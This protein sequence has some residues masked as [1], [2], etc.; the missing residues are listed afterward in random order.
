MKKSKFLQSLA[1][2][3]LGLAT[4]M[5]ALAELRQNSA[6]DY[7][8][9][10]A[11]DYE[12]FRQM[13]ATGNPYANAVLTADIT[14]KDVI[15]KGDV[16]FHYRGTFDGQ[17][18]TITMDN[19]AND[20]E[21]HPWGLFQ[22]TEP[23]CV[24]KNLKVSGTV[25]NQYE[26]L[27]SIVGEAR[28]TRVENCISDATLTAN[29]YAG[30]LIGA[31][32]GVNFV[33]N[34]AFIGSINVSEAYGIIGY[35]QNNVEI[36]SCYVD[37]TF[38]NPTGSNQFM[39]KTDAGQIFL[40]N[41]Y[42]KRNN[43]AAGQETGVT[44]VSSSDDMSN[45]K[46]CLDLNIKGRNGVVWY[47]HGDHPYPFKGTNGQFVTWNS[48]YDQPII[49]QTKCPVN[50]HIYTGNHE[51]CGIC[52]A[53]DP[54]R[55]IDPL[56]SAGEDHMYANDEI[57][58]GLIRYKL[59]SDGTA[60]VKGT[61]KNVQ[62]TEL[63]T[64][65]H[66]PEVIR[67]QNADY[68]VTNIGDGAFGGSKIEYCYIPKTIKDI[69]NNA[70]NKSSELTYVHFADG[71][72]NVGLW[73]GHDVE[74]NKE[75]FYNSPIEKV[76]IGRNL[77]WIA[78]VNN[79]AAFED[80]TTLTNVFFGPLVTRV[81]N[82]RYGDDPRAGYNYELFLNC[83]NIRNI[84]F[85]G[86]DQSLSTPDIEGYIA[87]GLKYATSIYVNRNITSGESD[88]TH[89]DTHSYTSYWKNGIFKS[90]ENVTFG[91]YVKYVGT[92]LLGGGESSYN[93]TLKNVDFTYATRL[94]RIY[95][96]AFKECPDATFVG[97]AGQYPLKKI[98]EEAFYNCDK[99]E[100]INFGTQLE[101]I[102]ESAFDDCAVLNFI[103]IP[104]TVTTIDVDA[105]DDCPKLQGVSFES[106]ATPLDYSQLD[107]RFDGDTKIISTLYLGRDISNT[108]TDCSIL[109]DDSP[110][111]ASDGSLAN[112]TIGPEVTYLSQGLFYGLKAIS[113]ITFEYAEQKLKFNG[114]PSFVFDIGE[115]SLLTDYNPVS[116]LLIDR[117]LVNAE[118]KL[119][120]G[121]EWGKARELVRD[122]TFGEHIYTIYE[123]QFEG[124]EGLQTLLVSSAIGQIQAKAFK[125]AD[126]LT[127][128][129]FAG[130][131]HIFEEAFANCTGLKT[132]IVGDDA[133]SIEEGAFYN[134][135]KIEEIII[136]S[137]GSAVESSATAFSSTTYT[138]AKLRSTYDTSVE[139][140]V[141]EHAPWKLFEN[142]P[143]KQ[144]NDYVANASD[145]SGVYEHA[146]IPRDVNEGQLD[147]LYIPF[148]WD[149]YF[150]GSD[151]EVY[152]LE[153]DEDDRYEETFEDININKGI[154]AY[155]AVLKQVDILA[156]RT[157][158]AGIY[159][160]KTKYSASGVH[161]TR[162]LFFDN[163]VMVTNA[164]HDI[165]T[166]DSNAGSKFVVGGNERDIEPDE[167][168]P[169]Y[170]FEDGVIKMV[171]ET[172]SFHT[173]DV[174]LSG[175]SYTDLQVYNVK[176]G[177]GYTYTSKM[178]LS[179]HALLEG[180]AT[181]YN[182][183]YNVLAP[184]WCTVYV[185]TGEENGTV[186]M[187]EI[188]D[189][190][191]TARQ[192]VV[193]KTE[194]EAALGAN[195]LMTYVTNGSSATDLYA[196]NLL[197][198]VSEDTPVA[199]VS[200]ADGYVYVLSC[201]SQNKNTG[202]Y[203]FSNG[204]TLGAGKAY[205][206]PSD[207]SNAGAKACLF[208][209]DDDSN[210]IGHAVI[211]GNNGVAYDLM[212]KRIDADQIDAKG[213]YIIDNKKVIK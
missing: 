61:H 55:K 205:L 202:F 25:T 146:F 135:P 179:F 127:T 65:V 140:I 89:K 155:N 116:S 175:S 191:I 143:F 52:G 152:V 107:G 195:D 95:D 19:V 49:G 12:E 199:D 18:H 10:S 162:N 210:G 113:S 149:S 130:S 120:K 181:F 128:V 125:G 213:I 169:N 88:I 5:P 59:N 184:E 54:D 147:L 97:L 29:S 193:I 206:K 123:S 109:G 194:N 150:F 126:A 144:N 192:A 70:F 171:N 96:K 79:D 58:V 115:A 15:G 182:E 185:V 47:Q 41:Y 1:I 180:Y 39:K 66:I 84:Y 119:I 26:A 27:G 154:G 118:G 187:A 188:E 139:T 132:I 78:D 159:A 186:Q 11:T 73:L 172:Q 42:H 36:K 164:K 24:I 99:L 44:M 204:K 68:T 20:T 48:T 82:Y 53:L 45:G 200:G 207:F 51:I 129:T 166:S 137:D 34:C 8:I 121:S 161:A 101:S 134:C 142:R 94:E 75:L 178:A 209:F 183:E 38:S 76:Y 124:F 138:N 197:H 189:R 23:G 22:Y 9:A 72:S 102:G 174:V 93:H 117:Y 156:V 63:A 160:V 50:G 35:V 190:V 77:C 13:V 80:R 17:G 71:P 16:Q 168:R 114:T 85:M 31:G 64:A 91:P 3:L 153:T 87:D 157:L 151:A 122:I 212:G 60:T 67:Y 37:A 7:E 176:L 92:D 56:Q 145:P 2:T 69:A 133:L 32:Y 81:G 201:N 110:F 104:G 103:S 203:K 83:D 62:G 136:N 21:N 198:G 57:Y 43:V 14:V 100:Y 106:S 167:A 6:G 165:M 196:Q 105:F 177:T 33:E 108:P 158:P 112:I 90:C 170:V 141:F 98:G 30:G 131:T 4:T 208:T 111:D 46:L 148:Q 40:N 173:G 211:D 86:S 163:G 28:G 74:D